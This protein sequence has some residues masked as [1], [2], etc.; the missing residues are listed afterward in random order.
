MP[1]PTSIGVRLA[2]AEGT[3][4][5]PLA[6][7]RFGEEVPLDTLRPAGAEDWFGRA[8]PSSG[9]R[10]GIAFSEDGTWLMGHFRIGEPASEDIEQAAF[11]AYR[12]LNAFTA[13]SGYPHLQRVW[14]FMDRLNHGQGDDER[15]RR[16]CVGR[17]RAIARPGFESHLPAATV[18]GSDRPGLVLSFLAAREPGQQIENPRQT[19]AFHYPRDYGP[20]GPSFS[21][22][23]LVGQLL[24]VSGTAAVVGHV[25]LHP[26]DALAQ[27]DEIIANLAAL[28]DS[29]TGRIAPDARGTWQAQALR[30][31]VRHPADADAALARFRERLDPAAPIAVLRGDISRADL[32]VEMEGVW[33]FKTTS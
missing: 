20:I 27:V 16:F 9:A 21:R 8:V 1:S 5:A 11:D 24:L 30:L 6:R 17:H 26:H 28:H 2:A 22:A 14:N 23:I 19:S 13:A 33:S 31:Y 32:M 15:Y 25:T 29:A 7:L 3:A 18:I 10:D 12:R 4:P